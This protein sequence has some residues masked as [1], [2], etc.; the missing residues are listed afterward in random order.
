FRGRPRVVAGPARLAERVGERR[1]LAPERLAEEALAAGQVAADAGTPVLD[2]LPLPV[3][4]DQVR[5]GRGD[6][7]GN[8][9]EAVLVVAARAELPAPGRGEFPDLPRRQVARRRPR[10]DELPGGEE[11]DSGEAVRPQD[12]GGVRPFAEPA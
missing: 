6:V 2:R 3:H 4:E 11:A 1:R 9:R 7:P 12:R 8:V 10:P 5:Q